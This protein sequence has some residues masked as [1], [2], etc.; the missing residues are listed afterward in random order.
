MWALKIFMEFFHGL[1]DIEDPSRDQIQRDQRN[2]NGDGRGEGIHE[3]QRVSVALN[4]NEP[5]E[6][7]ETKDRFYP[8]GIP[9]K[10]AERKVREMFLRLKESDPD[11]KYH[12]ANEHF[13]QLYP[14]AATGNPRHRSVG[15]NAHSV[16]ERKREREQSIRV[17]ISR[18]ELP[19]M[20]RV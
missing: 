7:R 16:E 3:Y 5:E 6:D 10:H 12:D 15:Q 9:E 8:D 14:R 4:Q 20:K 2:S 19:R 1:R 13:A 17:R 11:W 18:L